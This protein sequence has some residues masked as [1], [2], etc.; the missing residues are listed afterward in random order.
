MPWPPVP[1]SIPAALLIGVESTPFA[2]FCCALKLKF[3]ILKI[4]NR[5]KIQRHSKKPWLTV[6]NTDP[7]DLK[8]E[9][10]QA[11]DGWMGAPNCQASRSQ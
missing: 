1:S 6:T 9:P 7:G 11:T 4:V 5:K 8:D 10:A 3:I 2:P